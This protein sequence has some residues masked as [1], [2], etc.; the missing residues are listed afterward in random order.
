MAL[1]ASEVYVQPKTK[2]RLYWIATLERQHGVS[3]DPATNVTTD[4]IADRLL[5]ERIE[6]LYPNIADLERQL[7]HTEAELIAKLVAHS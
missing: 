5:N 7:E 4:Q 1:R 3:D 2:R 6:Q